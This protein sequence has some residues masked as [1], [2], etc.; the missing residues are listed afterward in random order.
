MFFFTIRPDGRCRRSPI[1][2]LAWSP[3]NIACRLLWRLGPGAA[4]QLLPDCDH[5]ASWRPIPCFSPS[6]QGDIREGSSSFLLSRVLRE[7]GTGR[8]PTVSDQISVS[9]TNMVQ[10]AL[11]YSVG[12]AGRSV[13][14]PSIMKRN[15]AS[16]ECKTIS[17]DGSKDLPSPKSKISRK[18]RLKYYTKLYYRKTHCSG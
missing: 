12:R 11:V 8:F 1:L 16:R 18:R 15:K 5:H 3:V 9:F 10:R 17:C 13:Q 4:K 6:L 2:I 14:W 7:Y